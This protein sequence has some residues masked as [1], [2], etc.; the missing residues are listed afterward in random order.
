MQHFAEFA[1]C[2]NLGV[3]GR[4]RAEFRFVVGLHQNHSI[5]HDDATYFTRTGCLVS[6][7]SLLYGEPHELFVFSLR[8]VVSGGE[9]ISH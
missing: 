4:V 3:G 6:D 9:S 7:S 2:D 8:L 1:E 5:A